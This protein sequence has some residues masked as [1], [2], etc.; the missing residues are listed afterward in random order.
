MITKP[1]HSF[2]TNRQAKLVRPLYLKL[3][4]E[5]QK[6]FAEKRL[7]EALDFYGWRLGTGFL[8]TPFILNVLSNINPE[9]AYKLLENEEM[10]GWL[11]MAKNNTG[12]IWE[13]WEGPN[14]QQGISSLNHYS[15]GAMVEWLFNGMC[16]IN[17]EGENKFL[18]KPIIG[19]NL[20]YAK[21]SY[22]SIYGKVS[23]SWEKKEEKTIIN[24]IVPDNTEAHFI[25]Q[26]ISEVLKAGTY[27][28]EI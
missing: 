27:K 5:Q 28:Y 13:G 22:E 20:K 25:Y 15:K 23:L 4:S 18:L 16:G 7:I 8:S 21:A 24:I 6:D 19:G 14:A 17:I 11:Y 2:D 3:L 10:P 12:T 1:D 26:N 9:Y